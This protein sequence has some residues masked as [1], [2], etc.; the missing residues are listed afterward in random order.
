MNKKVVQN[1]I[2]KETSVKLIN[3]LSK[4]IS[5]NSNETSFNL[6]TLIK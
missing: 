5:K 4:N 1:K 6:K 3:N 2:N